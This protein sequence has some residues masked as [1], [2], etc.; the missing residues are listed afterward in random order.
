MSDITGTRVP[1]KLNSESELKDLMLSLNLDI[2]LYGSNTTKS[3]KELWLEYINNESSLFV[4]NSSYLL[5][6]IKVAVAKIRHPSG[7]GKLLREILQEWKDIGRVRSRDVFLSGKFDSNESY[8]E[9]ITREILE[10]LGSV[11]PANCNINVDETS[12]TYAV[13]NAQSSSYPGLQTEYHSYTAYVDV[14]GI[15]EIDEFQTTETTPSH[16]ILTATWQWR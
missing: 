2:N 5:R 14:D 1:V 16:G 3:L 7:N 13:E 6:I 10:E 8:K 15:P 12:V 9:C 11:L 4:V